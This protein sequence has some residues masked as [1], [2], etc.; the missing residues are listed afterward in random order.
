MKLDKLK[1]KAAHVGKI[2]E[3]YR[4]I[5]IGVIII[6]AFVYTIGIINSQLSPQRDQTAYDEARLNID[7]VEFDQ[8]AVETI[9]RLRDLKVDVDSIFAPGRTN[10]FE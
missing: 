3:R 8:K 6:G 2:L 9:V 4:Y 1:T 5:L 10:P 7:K